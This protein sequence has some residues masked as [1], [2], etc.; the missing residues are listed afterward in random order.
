[1]L[2]TEFSR[3]RV[4]YE[5]SDQEY[6]R[7]IATASHYHDFGK[8]KL[9]FNTYSESDNRNRPLLVEL[10]NEDKTIFKHDR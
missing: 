2:I 8:L 9:F 5:F 10:T 4:D 3:L 1:M 6:N 7:T